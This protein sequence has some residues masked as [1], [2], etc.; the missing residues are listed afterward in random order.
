MEQQTGWEFGGM[1][2]MVGRR[3]GLWGWESGSSTP[4]RQSAPSPGRMSS[5]VVE[6]CGKGE[7]VS[8]GIAAGSLDW[9]VGCSNVRSSYSW[10]CFS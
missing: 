2:R 6:G 3:L 10:A 1:V 4:P 8:P 7:T 5:W 9:V